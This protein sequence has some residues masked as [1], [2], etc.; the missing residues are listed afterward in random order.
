MG[1]LVGYYEPKARA[2]TLF[3]I[4]GT[5]KNEG[6]KKRSGIRVKAELFRSSG[7]HITSKSVFAGNVLSGDDLRSSPKEAI[8]KTMANRWGDK[9]SNLDLGPGKSIPF[10][11]VFFEAPA[12]IEEYRLEVRE[13]E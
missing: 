11:V 7:E 4:K 1:N 10:M 5:V 3:V 6:R 8:E 13:G 2:G 12:G 9:L